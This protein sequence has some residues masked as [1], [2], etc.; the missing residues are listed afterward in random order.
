[1]AGNT[2]GQLFRLTTF[3]ESHGE[4]IG[5]VIDGC[6]AGLFLDINV[7]QAELNRRRP[8]LSNLTS[9]RKEDDQLTF[10]SGIFEGKTTGSPL[11]FMIP[12]EDAQS[13]DYEML[14]NVMRPS[15]ADY[16]WQAKYGIRDHRG[17]GRAS[18]R[19]TATRV[20]GG[21]VARQLLNPIGIEIIAY[22]AGVGSIQMEDYATEISI[23]ERNA[24]SVA[25]PDQQMNALMEQQILAIKE[26]GDSLGSLVHCI[27]RNMPPGL[28]E[29]VFDRLDAELAKAMMSIPAVKAVEIGSGIKASTMKASEHNDPFIMNG[30]ISNSGNHSGGI[31]GGISNGMPVLL[32]ISFK[33]PSSIALPQKSLDSK[34]NQIELSIPGRHD[35]CLVPRALVVV[36]A[37]AAL[38]IVDAFLR[39]KQIKF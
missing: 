37:M 7:V 21:A 6:P 17:G 20:V 25:C 15:H 11:A 4:A 23:A 30:K 29:P 10:L 2:F 36:E 28:G 8:G 33:P 18:G 13:S 5:G 38:V 27:V 3:G 1:M 31:Q 32:K 14:R 24:Y 34:G 39:N 26:E 19:E 9:P 35:P 16:T 12:N 22:T